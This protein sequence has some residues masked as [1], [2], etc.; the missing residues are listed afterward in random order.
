[1]TKE[2]LKNCGGAVDG[3]VDESDYFEAATEFALG[4]EGSES[5]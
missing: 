5:R 1:M 3:G 4:W 2:S